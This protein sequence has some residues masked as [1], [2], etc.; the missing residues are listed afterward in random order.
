ME[1]TEKTFGQ[2][3][4][5]W[6]EETPDNYFMI[7][8]DRGLHMTYSEFRERVDTFAKGLLSIGV[9]KGDKVGIWAKNIPD[10]ITM[11]F[12]AARIGA[13][14][15]T[16]NTNY[17]LSELEYLVRNA[18]IHTLCIMDSYRDSDYIGMVYELVPELK[19]MERGY[20]R[21]EKFPELRNVVYMGQER[22]RGMYS[23]PEL[24]SLGC[25]TNDSV[26]EE[27]EKEVTCQDIIMM[28]YTSG[29]TGFPKGVLLTHHNILNNGLTI[30]ECMSY[31][32]EDKVLTPVPMFHCFGCVLSL[33]AVITHGSAMVMVE[34]FDPLKV[35]ASIHRERCTAVY[36][37]PTMFIAELNH[38]MFGMFDLT[39]LRTGIMAGALCPIETMKEVMEKMH[40]RDIIIVYGLTESSPG[41]T[42]TRV[43]D[44]P[45]IRATTVGR[46]LPFV[47]VKVVDPQGRECPRG[48]Q[49]ELCC[50][51]YNVMKGYYKDPEATKAVMYEDGFLRSGDLGVM[52]EDGYVRV[53]GRIKEMLIRGGE[54]IYPREIENFIYQ[55]PQVEDV[56]VAGI[57]SPKYGEEVAA[58]IRVRKGMELTSEEVREFCRGKI[59]RYKI[60][61]YVFM[62]NNYPMTASGK[63]QKYKLKDLGLKILKD[64]GIEIV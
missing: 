47:E 35:L 49:G 40:C 11:M 12:A 42:A 2:W 56:Q 58:Y 16:I 39:S 30:G 63:I 46:A 55:M 51:G 15:V 10:W 3:L 32:T 7:Y 5:K 43:T 60:P 53:T 25:Y 18:D 4:D 57:P 64:K 36:G 31:S 21:S 59:A 37:V 54:N 13:V 38:P 9:R 44:S 23:T 50:R 8:S 48:V 26:L 34:E 45:E 29:T 14:Y 22:Y 24:Y 28:L 20:L 33:C 27:A 62:V 17:K 61:K 1:L 41:M 52:D 19:T 6:A